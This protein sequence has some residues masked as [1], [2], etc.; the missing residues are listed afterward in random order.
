MESRDAE[1]CAALIGLGLER[2]TRVAE[3]RGYHVR[4]AEIGT[5]VWWTSDLR[6]DRVNLWLSADDLVVRA[7]VG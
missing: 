2:A 7:T 5:D 4:S 6:P 3:K 1:L